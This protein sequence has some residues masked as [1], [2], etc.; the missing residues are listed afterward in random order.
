MHEDE[1]IDS[2]SEIVDHYAGALGQAFQLPDGERFPHVEDTEEYKAHEK[3]FP[4]QRNSDEGDQLAGDFI[5]D[6]ELWIFDAGC[7]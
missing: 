7:A 6:D 1:G 3:S 4:S 2:G 5:D